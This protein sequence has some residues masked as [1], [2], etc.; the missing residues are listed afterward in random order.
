MSEAFV[1]ARPPGNPWQA[2][3]KFVRSEASMQRAQ[4]CELCTR[5]LSA[6]H[7]HLI[8]LAQRRLVCVC[9]ACAVLFDQPAGARYRRVPRRIRLVS[10]FW[11]PDAAW[12]RLLIPINMAFFYRD[13]AAGRVVAMYP[14][15]AGATESLPD[16]DAWQELLQN[17]PL[18]ETLESDVEAL[19]V[20]RL[21]ERF[22]F[23]AAE[24]YLLPIDRCFQLTGLVRTHWR[25]LSGGAEVWE[26]LRCFF[27]DLRAQAVVISAPAAEVR[28]A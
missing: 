9:D 26:Q 21:G 1:D 11:L 22:G 27:A 10:D 12:G 20:N 13:T 4:S 16:D 18:L 8:E 6:E 14:S 25:G 19:L 23:A 17:N 3:R 15:P 2:L 7:Q 24:C 28:D 5:A